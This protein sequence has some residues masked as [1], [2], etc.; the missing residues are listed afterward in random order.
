MNRR[1]AGV[2]RLG[3]RQAVTV[4]YV[5]RHEVFGQG[6]FDQEIAAAFD[7]KIAED[8]VPH[9]PVGVDE[10][11][12]DDHAVGI[13]NFRVRRRDFGRNGDDRTILDMH[14]ATIQF[15]DPFIHTQYVAATDQILALRWQTAGC[16]R[17]VRK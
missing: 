10:A 12:H 6:V 17:I 9:M 2:N 3:E 11:R 7:Q 8:R 1:E 4:V 16:S 14:I 15:T 5:F 13:D